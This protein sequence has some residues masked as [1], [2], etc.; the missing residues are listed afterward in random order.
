ME[1]FNLYKKYYDSLMN[2]ESIVENANS[3]VSLCE[4]SLRQINSAYFDKIS[5]SKW[6]ELGKVV[7]R[8]SIL[9][10]LKSN[11]TK[12][13]DFINN[14]LKVACDLSI[15]SLLPTVI[16]IKTEDENLQNLR[17]ELTTLNG[18]RSVIAG[19][20]AG[21]SHYIVDKNGN[22][23]INSRWSALKGDLDYINEEIDKTQTAIGNQIGKL[24]TLCEEANTIISSILELDGS[25]SA[26]KANLPNY[27]SIPIPDYAS[28]PNELVEPITFEKLLADSKDGKFPFKIPS[29]SD[30]RH[31]YKEVDGKKYYCQN[32]EDGGYRFKFQ[33]ENNGVTEKGFILMPANAN[34]KYDNIFAFY[35]GSNQM[36]R[37]LVETYFMGDTKNPD[38]PVLVFSRNSKSEEELSHRSREEFATTIAAIESFTNY[39][40]T[41]DAKV[42]AIG[43]SRGGQELNMIVAENPNLLDSATIINGSIKFDDKD[44]VQN[45]CDC[46]EGV[47]QKIQDLTTSYQNAQT[48]INIFVG[49]ADTTIIP[50]KDQIEDYCSTVD[51]S[52]NYHY[53]TPGDQIDFNFGSDDTLQ[54]SYRPYDFDSATSTFPTSITKISDSFNGE[55]S[56]QVETNKGLMDLYFLEGAKHGGPTITAC[57]G[58]P[59][60]Y[61][62]I[63]KSTP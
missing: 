48:K 28:I 61:D 50:V 51:M 41:S 27:A 24:K 7:V 1:Y 32:T 16:K 19:A 52:T 38:F 10:T 58:N 11:I 49:T 23:K 35:C 47:K 46:P 57:L 59:Q 56:K 29:D 15:D 9:V 36:N 5:D 18:T 54:T 25:L 44:W 55:T 31:D 39:F 14:N 2:Q 30:I 26:N 63:I 17:N 12:T 40:G 21:T 13:V 34:K 53:L 3:L 4:N 6:E 62:L 22:K 43:T 20:L 42:H 60:F 33:Y 8:N 37:D 45:L